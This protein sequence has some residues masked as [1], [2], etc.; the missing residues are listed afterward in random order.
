MAKVV[1]DASAILALLHRETGADIV[2]ENLA[3]AIISAVNVAEAG[4]RL[5][6]NG[7]S[8]TDVRSV[9]AALALDVA[10]FDAE[11]AFQSASLR[12]GTRDKGLSLGDR[13]C[14]ALAVTENLP[15]L[16]A[17]RVWAELDVGVEVRLIRS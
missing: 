2:A 6:D 5:I 13:A 3:G 12:T 16:T 14:L 8:D 11:M 7:M 17:D 1:L 9:L 4:S 10:V 15:T